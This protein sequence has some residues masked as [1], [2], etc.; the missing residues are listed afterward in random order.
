M[1]VDCDSPGVELDVRIV[2]NGEQ[3]S[4]SHRWLGWLVFI[5]LFRSHVRAQFESLREGGL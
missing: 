1:Q 2:G 4:E 5:G 3:L